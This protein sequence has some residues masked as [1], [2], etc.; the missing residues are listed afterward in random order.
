VS[1][2]TVTVITGLGSSDL[3]V[4]YGSRGPA[5]A[6]GATGATGSQGDRAGLKYRFDTQTNNGAP[7]AGHL[8]FNSATL[9]A[10]TRISIR[11]TD[12]DGNDTSALLALIDDSTSTIKARVIIRSNTNSDTSHFNFL[13]TSVTDEGNHYHIN[14]T[15]V[16]GFAF[17]DNEIVTFD[18]YVTGNKGADGDGADKLPLAGGAMD[19]GAVITLDIAPDGNGFSTD[20]EVAGWGFGV[21]QK[22]NG[23]NTDLY[24][25]VD[26]N[27]FH[28]ETITANSTHLSG[29]A[30][31]FDNG[32]K[33]KKGT[34]DAGI[35]GNGGIALKCSVDYELK[36]DAGRLYTMEQD[37]FTIRRV[38]RCRNIAPTATDD[39]TK[40]FVIGSLWVLDDG[41]SYECT[42]ATATA[43]AWVAHLPF[44]NGDGLAFNTATNT[45]SCN[46]NVARRAGN[47][48]FTG[49][50]NFGTSTTG[51]TT[52][53][54][55]QTELNDQA[56]TNGT[57]AVTRDLGDARY[58]A[59]YV[60]IKEDNV[61]ST[62]NT[63][64]KL[65]SV[66]LPVGTYQIDSNIAATAASSNGGFVFGLKAS[67]NIRISLFEQYG[68]DGLTTSNSVAA[69]DS[70]TLTGR[71]IS[72][73]NTL[74]NKRQLM[75]LLE[76]LTNNTE[77]SLEFSQATTTPAVAST[78]RKRAYIIARR[79]A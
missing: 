29:D 77:V 70:T 73:G 41:T 74:T 48:T 61:S 37:G 59:T 6:T 39:S 18:F 71:A 67:A 54:F 79:I 65:T 53:F 64:I 57:S 62:N 27:G 20:S 16:S 22:E 63:P 19:T 15:Y 45:L 75:G 3:E 31:T 17:S 66:T 40:G 52:T 44:V 7:S 28:A 51:V 24:A 47:Q 26:T 42:A 46:S 60:G 5:G 56:L 78:T 58:G 49:N 2:T 38:D 34:T 1:N 36:W 76:V 33:L 12:F 30:L 55:G 43:A 21:Q 25:Y 68:A 23:V 10:V 14:G 69:S 50:N 11:D 35:G 8:K 13:V 32:S 4:S 9:S 72:A